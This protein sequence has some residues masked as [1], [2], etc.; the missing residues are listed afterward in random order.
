MKNLKLQDKFLGTTIASRLRILGNAYDAMDRAFG[1]IQRVHE[2]FE[3]EK[4]MKIGDVVLTE[5]EVQY[6]LNRI[7]EA[8]TAAEIILDKFD[9][10]ENQIYK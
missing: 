4:K 9:D 5:V 2:E 3:Q 1:A 8:I 6:L 7:N 10:Y